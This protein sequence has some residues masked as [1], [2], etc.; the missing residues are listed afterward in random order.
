MD[1]LKNWVWAL[2][3]VFFLISPLQAQT[4]DT[5]IVTVTN[6]GDIFTLPTDPDSIRICVKRCDKEIDAAI[7]RIIVPG[8][9][10]ILTG[11]QYSESQG[12]ESFY[13][14]IR[15]PDNNYIP[16]LEPN[17]GTEKVVA[18]TSFREESLI[19][20]AGKFYLSPGVYIIHLKHYYFLQYQ[21][22][23][24]L[25]PPDTPMTGDS[26]ESV[27]FFQFQFKYEGD[28]QPDFDLAIF[29]N[30]DKDSIFPG[31]RLQFSLTVS[32]IGPDVAENVQ[33]KDYL[34]NFFELLS[35]EPDPDSVTN[36]V[37]HWNIPAVEPNQSEQITYLV[38]L[39]AQVSDTIASL[40]NFAFVD[41][42]SDRNID[43]NFAEKSIQILH[44]QPNCDLVIHKSSDKD[45]VFD[46][47]PF[48][49]QIT[50]ENSGPDSAFQVIV[51]D[52]LPAG[53]TVQNISPSPDSVVGQNIL[54][55]IES[56]APNQS[57]SFYLTVQPDSIFF[58]TD[59]TI[60][61]HAFTDALNDTLKS[62]NH[63]QRTV[64]INWEKP[65]APK[66]CD[67]KIEK[68]AS[69]DTIHT[70]DTALYR[71][72]I[73]NSG[74]A[75][76]EDITVSDNLPVEFEPFNFSVQPD[77]QVSSLLVWKIDSVKVNEQKD[78]EFQVRLNQNFS[79]TTFRIINR[80]T[81]EVSN[82]TFKTNNRDS[83]AIVFYDF[84]EKNLNCDLSI[85]KSADKDSAFAGDSVNYFISIKNLTENTAFQVLVSDSLPEFL[86]A[87]N[88]SQTPDSIAGNIIFWKFDSIGGFE[89]KEISLLTKV[90]SN[91]TQ[92][93][94]LTNVAFVKSE[95]DTNAANDRDAFSLFVRKKETP[96]PV[97]YC[98]VKIQKRADKDSASA[99]DSVNY[100][101]SIKNLT[102]NT[103]FQVLVADSL[104]EFLTAENFS[105]TPDSIAGNLIFWK[106]D[107]IS[108]LEEKEISLLAKVDSTL[109]Q[110]LILTNTAIVKSENDTNAANDRNDLSLFVRKKET[111]PPVLY[112]DVKIQKRADK[113]SIA[114]GGVIRF[115]LTVENVGPDIA[116][117]I[118]VTDSLPQWLSLIGTNPP[119][120]DSSPSLFWTI[121][122]LSQGE[123]F[124]VTI[125][126]RAEEIDT[127]TI[128]Q[129][130]NRAF[131]STDND[132]NQN[133]NADSVSVML[134]SAK[135]TPEYQLEL[136]KEASVDSVNFDDEFDYEIS[137]QNLG[138]DIARQI[139]V[140]DSMTSA[141]IPL[142]F[143]PEPDSSSGT[144]YFWYFD[145]I[146][147]Q[148]TIL[149]TIH[150]KLD[151]LF[152]TADSA[153]WNVAGIL[154]PENENIFGTRTRARIIPVDKNRDKP[155]NAPDLQL[156]KTTNKDTVQV[157]ESFTYT[158][159]I[160]NNGNGTAFQISVIDT[161]P[162]NISVFNFNPEPDSS[163]GLAFFWLIDSLS[164]GAF[165]EITYDAVIQDSQQQSGGFLENIV[166]AHAE[167]DTNLVGENVKKHRIIIAEEKQEKE[168]PYNLTVHK[169]ADKDTVEAGDSFVYQL[170]V[171]NH[172]P[173][174]AYDVALFDSLPELIIGSDF[175]PEPDSVHQR[176]LFWFIDTLQPGQE[177]IV[178]FL[179]T[180]E[181][182]LPKTIM[183][184]MNVAGVYAAND[185]STLDD[186]D[187]VEIIAN[188]QTEGIDCDNS[189]YFSHNVYEPGTGKA[190][191][192]HFSLKKSQVIQLDLY[193]MRGYHISTIEE[194]LYHSGSNTFYW[195]GQTDSGQPVGSG[196]YLIALRT[197][198][199]MCWKKIIIVR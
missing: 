44:R 115:I 146:L 151:S 186:E 179:A 172:G 79:D 199:M 156:S 180:L 48:Q 82:D 132:T 96:P 192:I 63:A 183:P 43:N 73:S 83:A 137:V 165:F 57:A 140:V 112:C 196:V 8:F 178:S 67:V 162:A 28:I 81:V 13:L 14:Q 51:R 45:S 37:I 30:S 6:I 139:T 175:Q 89:E 46:D 16:Q 164:P 157:G 113:D 24:F 149:I 130:T 1:R 35:A 41:T 148:Q 150:A 144:M 99:G 33:V 36:G 15:T 152:A 159:H 121:D 4:I 177:F 193:D 129:V 85:T 91:L 195:N 191:E 20:D 98:D 39:S 50:V 128:F 181:L 163:N 171:Y 136:K 134:I 187:E 173:G 185:T 68:T 2:W 9:Y 182:T 161:L 64:F 94:I 167:N 145:S 92:N 135:K 32:N 49:F 42:T 31:E 116:K 19:R 154:S 53:I 131:V 170:S 153:I 126:A 10:R 120:D 54:W 138:P 158:I 104:P 100:F 101:I 125:A 108:G 34:P 117:E 194:D 143:S 17:A 119:T 7:I 124:S 71:I 114:T 58:G 127:D 189:Y 106:F 102:E 78:I 188:F 69:V 12:N 5:T 133:N 123:K 55:N 90:D 84:K 40:T 56:L 122:S 93:Q 110:N 176:K 95:N 76:A 77:S 142:S 62:N 18:D 169:T 29:K 87:E 38:D 184:I 174:V 118:A 105:Q 107:S 160:S 155:V 22:P 59:T 25:N 168:L 111:P 198:E 21:Y 75:T 3:G 88:F 97:L 141:I 66:Y 61:N 166:V 190:L 70:G 103:A 11:V 197:G 147:V 74:P 27:H 52:S 47:S 60:E 80:A 72:Q 23:Q 26:P 65:P 86:T 109:S